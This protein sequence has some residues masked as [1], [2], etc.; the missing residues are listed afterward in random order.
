M[1]LV[2]T[3]NTF[4]SGSRGAEQLKTP[5]VLKDIT[6][7]SSRKVGFIAALH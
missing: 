3:P 6:L 1:N 2:S 7:Q 5:V 4:N